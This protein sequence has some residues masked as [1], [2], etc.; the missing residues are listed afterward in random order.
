M[1]TYDFCSQSPS[2]GPSPLTYKVK[3]LSRLEVFKPNFL[4]FYT[5]LTGLWVTVQCD[6]KEKKKILEMFFR[7]ISKSTK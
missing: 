5:F 6:M 4:N 3:G 7:F 1:T 2:L